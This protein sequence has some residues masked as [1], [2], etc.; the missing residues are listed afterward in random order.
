MT[1]L[2]PWLPICSAELAIILSAGG[3]RCIPMAL[4]NRRERIIMA[5]LHA[6]NEAW[7]ERNLWR[8]S[9]HSKEVQK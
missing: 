9:N 4:P 2:R 7:R 1:D 3:S 6:R 5:R 8:R